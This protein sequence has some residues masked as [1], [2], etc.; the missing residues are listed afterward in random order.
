MTY[1]ERLWPAT[2][3]WVV[4]L[5]V[6]SSGGLVVIKVASVPVSL[7]VAAACMLVVAYGLVRTSSTV[8]VTWSAGQTELVAGRAHIP[9]RYL[10]AVEVLSADDVR[11]LRG[12]GADARAHLCQRG[13]IPTGVR[14]AIEDPQDTTP[15]WFI[16]SRTPGQLAEAIEQSSRA[17]RAAG[18]PQGS[19]A[20]GEDGQA[21][22]KQT[23]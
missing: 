21:H 14:V 3:V 1:R 15:Y 8:A 9:V 4:C 13:W 6:A 7:A 22:S 10:G 16:S 2:W 11:N 18:A 23:G 20:A 12:P 5:L 19:P 17:E